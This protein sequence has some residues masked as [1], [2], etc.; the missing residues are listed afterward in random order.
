VPARW[1]SRQ[2]NYATAEVVGALVRAARAVD[3]DLPGGTVA[4]G[5]LSRRA[6]GA[7]VEHKSH[8]SGRDADIFF[9]A[10]DVEGRPARPGEAMLHF[11]ESG[12]ATRWSPARGTAPPSAPVPALRFDAARNWAFVRALLTDPDVEVQWIFIQR[13]LASSLLAAA[14]SAGE[15]P[16]VVARA[17]FIM[18]EPTD[19]E[20]HDDH[21]HVRFYCAPA[22]RALGC[23][24][25]GPVRWLKKSWK[26]LAPPF[27]RGTS[28]ERAPRALG[29]LPAGELPMSW[30][31]A[32]VSS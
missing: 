21:A 9:Y 22:D 26:Y 7:S 30:V 27:G 25:R 5:D 8:Q 24:D 28:D 1:R 23:S 11:G 12:Q 29:A 20:P 19:S 10:A 4:I 15:D 13:A 14:T 3:R 18:H 6:G 31:G 32:V 17:A 2:S 16:A